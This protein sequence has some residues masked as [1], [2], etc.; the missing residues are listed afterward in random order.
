VTHATRISDAIREIRKNSFHVALLDL[1]LPDSSGLNG[2][3]RLMTY[4][5]DVPVIVLTGMNDDDAAM[6]G[7]ELGAQEFI[8]KGDVNPQRL[9]RTIRHA[10]KRK[11][12][13]QKRRGEG[14]MSTENRIDELGRII[15]DMA[16]EVHS[17]VEDLLE[18]ELT[19]QQRALV[20]SIEKTS[21]QSLKAAQQRKPEQVI[22]VEAGQAT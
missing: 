14:S 9:I 19:Q 7:I 11:Q 4:I 15:E 21:T 2:V 10:I 6:R 13:E 3:E 18:T 8:D 20:D 16:T 22:F 1:G 12:F 5:P 17:N